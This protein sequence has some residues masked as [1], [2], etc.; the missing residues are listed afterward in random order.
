MGGWRGR[1][2]AARCDGD[3][4]AGRKTRGEKSMG[5]ADARRDL[6]GDGTRVA[7]AG[8]PD[9]VPGQ[10]FLPGPVFAAP[11]HL[12]PVAGPQTA[13]D[14]YGRPD[15]PTR[16]RL[17]AAIGELEGGEC[18][19]F[20]TGQAAIT[21]VLLTVLRPGDT[22]VLPADGYYAVRAFASG[23]LARTRRQRRARPDGRAVPGPRRRTPGAARNA[24]QPRPGRVRPGRAV[25]GGAR[26]RR[27]GRRR[28]HHRHAA[29]AS[30]RST[31]API[32]WSRPA[33]RP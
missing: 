9:P 27:A 31:S 22:V 28:Q 1:M 25:G 8:L 11:Y 19:A 21:A 24:G 7:H 30:A 12:D 13:P 23:T 17:E 18:L 20:A 32:W 16:R 33:P 4:V 26:R 29:R 5:D 10:P 14:G 3:A 6:V 15:N 2:A